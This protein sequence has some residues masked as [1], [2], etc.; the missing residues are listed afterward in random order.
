MPSGACIASTVLPARV[1]LLYTY[2]VHGH[3]HRS[4]GTCRQHTCTVHVCIP[5]NGDSWQI[6]W[7]V[8]KESVE[9]V[10]RVKGHGIKDTDLI[11][12]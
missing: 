5:L 7:W 12:F 4:I 3:V 1:E 2:N 10:S 6:S 9:D 11:Y 8:T